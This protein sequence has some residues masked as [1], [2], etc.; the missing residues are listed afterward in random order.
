MSDAYQRQQRRL[1]AG[2]IAERY[3]DVAAVTFAFTYADP[4]PSLGKPLSKTFRREPQHSAL[5]DFDCASSTCVGGGFSLGQPVHD[6]LAARRDQI[7]GTLTCQ[8][9]QD[10]SRVNKNRCLYNFHYDVRAEYRSGSGSG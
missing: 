6:M 5:F 1:A 8:G 9:W 3:P 10:A 7:K 4:N 2:T